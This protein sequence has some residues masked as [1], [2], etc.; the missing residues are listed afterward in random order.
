MFSY[1][2][3]GKILQLLSFHRI[4]SQANNGTNILIYLIYLLL[5]IILSAQLAEDWQVSYD[6]F[7]CI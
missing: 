1:L 3:H 4:P 7:D 5:V 6:R 2:V